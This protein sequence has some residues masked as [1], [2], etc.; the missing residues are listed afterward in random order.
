MGRGLFAGISLN[1]NL[2]LTLN[3]NPNLILN[4][5]KKRPVSGGSDNLVALLV[6]LGKEPRRGNGREVWRRIGGKV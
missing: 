6:R 4:L 2:T 5:N 1:L 3:H